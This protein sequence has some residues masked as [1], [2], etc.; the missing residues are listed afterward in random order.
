MHSDFSLKT[1]VLLTIA[2]QVQLLCVCGGGG[3]GG[4][5]QL[6]IGPE[7]YPVI[8]VVANPVRG[9]LDRKRSEEHLQKLR[10]MKT[11]TK[12]TKERKSNTKH[13][14]I[15]EKDRRALD[16][17]S[18]VYRQSRAIRYPPGSQLLTSL[19]NSICT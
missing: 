2:L 1:N 7:P 11:K 16:G 9:L 19:I 12:T 8:Y 6:P 4:C 18:L 3:G 5:S 17:E 14:I 13:I 15:P 10:A